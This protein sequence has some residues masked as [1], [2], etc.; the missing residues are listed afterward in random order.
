MNSRAW[1]VT[2]TRLIGV[3]VLYQ[4][5]SYVAVFAD[6]Q[7]GYRMDSQYAYPTGYLVQAGI[8]L[9]FALYLLLG[10]EQL[11]SFCYDSK[12]TS[13]VSNIEQQKTDELNAT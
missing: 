12:E 4:F 2:G 3:W 6:F 7:L 9:L 5:V 13:R 10:T 11:A 1:F 8:Y